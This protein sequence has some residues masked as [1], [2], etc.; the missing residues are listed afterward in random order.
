M[1]GAGLQS[2]RGLHYA[3]TV[4]CAA[5]AAWETVMT[6]QNVGR[7]DFMRQAAAGAAAGTAVSIAAAEARSDEKIASHPAVTL[8]FADIPNFCGHEHW[9][10]I[11]A[12]GTVEEGFRADVLQGA[13]PTRGVTVWDLVLDPYGLGWLYTGGSSLDDAVKAAG[14]K[15]LFG[16]WAENPAAAFAAAKP[17][18]ERHRLTGVF[19]CTAR[20]IQALHGVDVG[21]FDFDAW[22]EADRRVAETYLDIHAWHPRAMA[23]AGFDGLVR[24]VHPEF[25]GRTDNESSATKEKAYLK[26]VMRIDPLLELWKRRSPRR[27]HLAD[28]VRVD[29]GDAK[30]W[31]EFI[32]RILDRARD[33]GAAGIKQLQAYHR[34]LDFEH[35]T[36]SEVK[37]RGDLSDDEA[38]AFED[39]VVHECCRQAHDR[40]W[41]HQVH[42]GTNNLPRSS[43][44]PLEALAKRYPD[45]AL[46]QLHCWP[47]LSESGY[48]AKLVPNVHL[49]TCWQAILNPAYY[50]EAMRMWLGYVPQHKIMCAHDATS[51]EMAAGSALFVREMLARE[52]TAAGGARD[53]AQA[54]LHD[55]AARMYGGMR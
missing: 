8:D 49:E 20:G 26:T 46:V 16:W 17:M 50:G 38:R 3:L 32:G 19:R 6:E 34:S 51:V 9:G 11:F 42:V 23:K 43:P 12:L 52:I 41:P 47:F 14:Q 1:G 27:D 45:M 2:F 55:N 53:T 10:S 25:Y 48:L 24:A 44:L 33:G 21:T 30:T 15:D 18:L 36:D 5:F 22:V 35:R 39:W 29:P 40:K 54:L 13:L 37:F 31:R 4:Q 7:R 28:M